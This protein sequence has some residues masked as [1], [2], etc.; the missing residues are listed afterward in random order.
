MPWQIIDDLFDHA[1]NGVSEE[2]YGY[3]AGT[4]GEVTRQLRLTNNIELLLFD[5]NISYVIV[6]LAAEIPDVNPSG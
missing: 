5:P 4:S 6:P 2:V 3:L 1:Q